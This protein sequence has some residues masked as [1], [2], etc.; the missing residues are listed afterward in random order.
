[1]N[2]HLCNNH[3]KDQMRMSQVT[4]KNDNSIK[5]EAYWPKFDRQKYAYYIWF[6]GLIWSLKIYLMCWTV[7]LALTTIN[8]TV[9]M[10]K[11]W[12]M[13]IILLDFLFTT[14]YVVHLCVYVFVYLLAVFSHF[15]TFRYR[16]C[17]S[18]SS[19]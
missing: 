15:P 2:Y 6:T 10:Y 14:Y 8:K 11:V 18:H 12:S 19:I 17:S 3:K 4:T 9:L 16:M 5:R 13:I 7:G 1:M